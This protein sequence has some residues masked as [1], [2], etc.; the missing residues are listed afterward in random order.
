[1]SDMSNLFEHVECVAHSRGGVAMG[2]VS[3]GFSRGRYSAS[4]RTAEVAWCVEDAPSP[5]R[6]LL[7]LLRVIKDTKENPKSE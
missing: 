5:E 1:M 7:E 3:L 6:A 2:G 4:V